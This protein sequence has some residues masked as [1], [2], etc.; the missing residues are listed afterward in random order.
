MR[1]DA[2]PVFSGMS[3]LGYFCRVKGGDHE[4]VDHC[5]THFGANYIQLKRFKLVSSGFGMM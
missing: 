3:M 5:Q 1:R 2:E 4:A